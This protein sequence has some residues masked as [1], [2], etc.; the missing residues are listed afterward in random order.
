MCL[1]RAGPLL[2]CRGLL[3]SRRRVCS[4]GWAGASGP[5][6]RRRRRPQLRLRLQWSAPRGW[7]GGRY[8]VLCRSWRLQLRQRRRRWLPQLLGRA[9]GSAT[10]WTGNGCVRR[11]LRCPRRQRRLPLPLR[12]TGIA[13][14]RVCYWSGRSWRLQLLMR[15]RRL[16]WRH[17]SLRAALRLL[18]Q[19]LRVLLPGQ[20]HMAVLP[21]R[22]RQWL[23]LLLLLLL[24]R[25]WRQLCP[26]IWPALLS[27]RGAGVRQPLASICAAAAADAD[28]AT[29]AARRRAIEL[30]RAAGWGCPPYKAWGARGRVAQYRLPLGGQAGDMR[31]LLRPPNDWPPA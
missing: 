25:Q 6:R 1:A 4:R 24:W 7:A 10:A 19:V 20:C 14:C 5:V 12:L 26:A 22:R 8:A 28:T 11:L 15:R 29:A 31:L 13:S 23:L 3:G 9:C 21:R 16:R 2:W 18:C 27:S 30:L 17:W